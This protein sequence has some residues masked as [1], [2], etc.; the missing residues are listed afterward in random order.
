MPVTSALVEKYIYIR[1]Y[2][3]HIIALKNSAVKW[4]WKTKSKYNIIYPT[5][6]L[7]PYRELGSCDVFKM[8]NL[9][10]GC[11]VT[12]GVNTTLP[13]CPTGYR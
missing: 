10:V 5:V 4:S 1:K 12:L 11:I 7:T 3:S 2:H 6:I 9:T 8:V 13:L